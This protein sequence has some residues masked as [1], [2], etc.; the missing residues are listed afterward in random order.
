MGPRF[1]SASDTI[2]L[3]LA[4]ALL[5]N[6]FLTVLPTCNSIFASNGAWLRALLKRVL[7]YAYCSVHR[8]LSG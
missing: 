5:P 7:V 6:R 1:V 4:L 3:V 2:V 8:I